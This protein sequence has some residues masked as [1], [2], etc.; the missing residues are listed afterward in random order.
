MA[1]QSAVHSVL[2]APEAAKRYGLSR[3]YLVKLLGRGLIKG[4]MAAGVWLIEAASLSKY[5]ANR[6][7][8]GRPTRK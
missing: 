7:P 1:P 2:T 5:L 6:R 4:R 8:R 3:S